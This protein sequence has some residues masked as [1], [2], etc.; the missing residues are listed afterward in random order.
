MSNSLAMA[1]TTV[2]LRNLLMGV[3]G[4]V[5]GT[6]VTTKPPDKARNGQT[7]NQ[8]NLFLYHTMPNAAWRNQP[9]SAEGL[10]SREGFPPLAL[11][12]LYFVTAYGQNDDEIKSHHLLGEAMRILHDNS[13]L[14]RNQIKTALPDNDL[15]EQLE[16]VRI[17]PTTI[18]AEEI[19]K[20]WAT[21]QTQYRL[22]AT[23]QV[24]VVL[25]ESEKR[26]VSPLPVLKRGQ[27]DRGV[28]VVA[29]DPP[30][31]EGLSQ[32]SNKPN[33][34]LGDDLVFRGKGLGE[35][36]ELHWHHAHLDQPVVLTAQVDPTGTHYGVH[37]PS[38]AED[39]KAMNIWVPGF[40]R[41][42]GVLRPT[43]IPAVTTNEIP[44]GL[45]P[46]ITIKPKTAQEGTVILTVTS[47]PRIR[48]GQRVSL[49]IG[50]RQFAVT[51]TEMTNPSDLKKPT[52]VK[53]SIPDMK[54]G[55]YAIRLRVDGVE[56]HPIK[57]TST[58]QWEF[59]PD[60]TLTVT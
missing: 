44:V 55:T 25:I 32:L 6:D 46:I 33:M 15:H 24:S 36:F 56:S 38:V 18:S 13:V 4:Q 57:K 23:Y 49:I 21:F 51:E 17:T 31:L 52:T 50:N 34:E 47:A 16:R 29:G 60:Q 58:G 40:F 45:A 59:D 48:S 27:D 7:G 26:K 20:W 35:Q 5:S 28:W 42:G 54:K 10:P 14:D 19:S 8:L 37:I 30:R 1:T 2:T 3:N 11:N 12:L 39:S 22:T 41:V 53:V 9:I 43:D